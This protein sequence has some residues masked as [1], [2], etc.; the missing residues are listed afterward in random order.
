MLKCGQDMKKKGHWVRKVV[1]PSW[2][3]KSFHY[4]PQGALPLAYAM[5]LVEVVSVNSERAG[6]I[7][8]EILDTWVRPEVKELYDEL[9]ARVP[10]SEKEDWKNK[11]KN[12]ELAFGSDVNKL[13]KDFERFLIK[14][15]LEK[16]VKRKF[17]ITPESLPEK[18]EEVWNLFS[19][20]MEFIKVGF[21]R[22]EAQ[23]KG[24]YRVLPSIN[25]FWLV[26]AVMY[27]TS[28]ESHQIT[29]GRLRKIY[30][31]RKYK[32]KIYDF[33]DVLTNQPTSRMHRMVVSNAKK[34]GRV[35][36]HDEKFLYGAWL[37][38][39]CRVV[40]SSIDKFCDK[41]AADGTIL[42]PKNIDKDIRPYDE[43]VGYEKRIRG[44]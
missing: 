24:R 1:Q 29:L 38:Y 20:I 4:W 42:D 39:Q 32:G 5:A 41:L 34:A 17:K 6:A 13:F 12:P 30:K 33:E 18:S 27:R 36:R 23:A 7:Y 28:F 11:I 9:I 40:H 26:L 37:W 16:V 15:N 14:A 21:N 44:K 3:G 31:V 35:L 19:L 8:Q 22:E 2:F 10:D 43:A 25:P